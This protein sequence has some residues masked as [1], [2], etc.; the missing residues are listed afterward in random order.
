MT[1]WLEILEIAK[2]ITFSNSPDKL[3]WKYESNGVYSSKSLYAIVNFRGIQPVYLP[4]VWDLKIAP[5]V[6]NFL[7]LFSQ[8]KILT[9]DNL[10]KRA[11]PKPL[12]CIL[13][14]E[15]ES[16]SHLFFECLISKLLWQEV[17]KIFNIEITDF[18]SSASKWLCSKRYIQFNIVSSAIIWTI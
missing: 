16:V 11:I 14:K 5:R 8:N 3:I 7:W 12:E 17:Q 18:L 4:V 15:I 9:R 2:G 1:Q 13:C 10:R 6:Q